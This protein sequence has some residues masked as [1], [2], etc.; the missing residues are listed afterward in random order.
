MKLSKKSESNLNERPF[1]GR[2]AGAGP[3]RDFDIRFH[4]KRDL[5]ALPELPPLLGRVRPFVRERLL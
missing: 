5:R 2:R 4:T 1:L 3:D